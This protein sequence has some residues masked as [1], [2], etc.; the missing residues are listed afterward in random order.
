MKHVKNIE[1]FKER[2]ALQPKVGDYVICD[3]GSSNAPELISFI[4][5]NVGK[6]VKYN[7]EN[8][9][10]PY[11]IEYENI[12]DDYSSTYFQNNKRLMSRVEI[13][14]FSR[15]K[16]FLKKLLHSKNYNL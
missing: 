8:M 10:A 12:P 14:H 9:N 11:V 6:I 2:P 3:E 13:I 15:D 1:T 7:K 4:K 16:E 5:K